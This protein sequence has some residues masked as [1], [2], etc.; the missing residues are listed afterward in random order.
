MASLDK[1]DSFIS[2][3]SLELALLNRFR[4]VL[5]VIVLLGIP[6][7]VSASKTANLGS[8]V[9]PQTRGHRAADLVCNPTDPPAPKPTP[10][11]VIYNENPYS[12][13]QYPQLNIAGG[14]NSSQSVQVFCPFTVCN[15]Y[16][17]YAVW[18]LGSV[19]QYINF[20]NLEFPTTTGTDPNILDVT[21]GN[22]PI[23]NGQTYSTSVNMSLVFYASDGSS[24]TYSTYVPIVITAPNATAQPT[25][26]PQPTATSYGQAIKSYIDS[27]KCSAGSGTYGDGCAITVNKTLS[28]VIGHKIPYSQTGETCYS[29]NPNTGQSGAHT[30][31]A[32]WVPD[33][34]EAGLRDGYLSQVTANSSL[35]GDIVVQDGNDAINGMNH[36]GFCDNQGC[37]SVLSNFGSTGQ[38]CGPT[39]ATFSNNGFN[40]N[41]NQAPTYYRVLK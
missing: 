6:L 11:Y 21:L 10:T 40:Y 36:I 33:V 29:D 31:S 17:G 9:C 19:G 14:P 13:R 7:A 35:G 24:Q 15:D 5:I 39:N 4:L 23:S 16:A 25:T 37:T 38:L 12:V 27:I 2:S 3:K 20:A 41:P 1:I 26:R 32:T 18:S 22:P 28:H 34:V 30:C 8:D